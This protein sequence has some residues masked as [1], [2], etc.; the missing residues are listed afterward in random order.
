V[1][2][3]GAA[4]AYKSEDCSGEPVRITG[5]AARL[6]QGLASFQVESGVAAAWE[7]TDYAGRQVEFVGP[8]ICVSPGFDIQSVK[9][10]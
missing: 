2:A 9:F 7:K 1:P 8:G 10:K 6:G 4:L 5:S 3:G